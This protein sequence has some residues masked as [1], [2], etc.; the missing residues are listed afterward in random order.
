[1]CGGVVA[2]MLQRCCAAM[3]QAICVNVSKLKDEIGG[4]PWGSL[5]TDTSPACLRRPC[6]HGGHAPT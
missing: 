3:L 4:R 1:M 6:S 2:V 5:S